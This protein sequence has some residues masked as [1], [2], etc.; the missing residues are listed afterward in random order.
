[1]KKHEHSGCPKRTL[2]NPH[3]ILVKAGIQK[4]KY[5][6]LDIGTG[7]GYLAVIS[8]E[9]MGS[10]S[11]VYALDCNKETVKIL[12]KE[13]S[14]KGI[15]NIFALEADAVNKF[16]IKRD[17]ADICIM[18]NVVHGFVP[19][20]EME[21]ILQNLNIVLKDDGKLII[22]DFK[23][24]DLSFGPPLEMRLDIKELEDILE[25]YGY[26]L[27]NSFDAGVNQYCTVFKKMCLQNKWC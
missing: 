1:M 16:P 5:V 6:L 24:D 23:K 10:G 7:S 20:R 21:K 22:L 9:I 25:P 4:G 12:E 26:I 14:N 11:T 15:K 13:L 19:N 8:A 2:E 18:S 3:E 27:I 17:S